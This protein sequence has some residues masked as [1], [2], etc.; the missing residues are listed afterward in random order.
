VSRCNGSNGLGTIYA[1][2]KSKVAVPT[3][4]HCDHSGQSE[5]SPIWLRAKST[6][7][8]FEFSAFL[9]NTELVSGNQAGIIHQIGVRELCSSGGMMVSTELL[10]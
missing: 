1:C 3:T 5:W 7:E 2:G 6:N 10:L 8:V 9:I 4:V